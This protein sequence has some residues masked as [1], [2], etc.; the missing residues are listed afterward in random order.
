[1]NPAGS[2]L[3]RMLLAVVLPLAGCAT[4][5][6]APAAQPAAPIAGHY[7]YVVGGHVTGLRGVGLSLRTARG[8]EIDVDDDGKFVFGARLE[9]GTAYAV[10][11]GREPI[12]PVQSCVVERGV[13]KIA[14]HNA[15]QIT[16]VCSTIALEAEPDARQLHASRALERSREFPSE[17]ER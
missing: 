12:S 16:V 3:A 7:E 6:R 15:M 5:P 9:D 17:L 14:A 8:E 2:W 10:S 13:G 4:A 11:I 1:M